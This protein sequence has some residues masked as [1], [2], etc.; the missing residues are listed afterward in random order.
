MQRLPDSPIQFQF[1]VRGWAAIAVGLVILAV[2][3]FLAIGFLIL[4]LPVLLLASILFWFLPKQKFHRVGAWS[5]KPPVTDT[6]VIEGHFK[7]I[8]NTS[9]R[10]SEANDA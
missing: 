2:V 3:A 1:G 9:D 4:I 8:D 5:E 10:N 7:V 6:T